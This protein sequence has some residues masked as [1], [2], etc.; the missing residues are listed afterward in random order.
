MAPHTDF[1]HITL[2]SVTGLP[3][4]RGAALALAHSLE[5]MP[6]ARAL[7]CSP[8]APHEM[9]R[10]ISHLSIAPLN[11]HEYSWFMLFALWRVVSTEFALVVQEDGWLLDTANWDDAFLDHDYVGA[12][13][14]LA[15]IE[16]NEGVTWGRRFNWTV[17]EGQTA[18]SIAPVLN[19][20]F[21]LRSQRLMRALVDRPHIRVEV[22]PPDVFA[23]SP[24]RMQWANDA[25]QED[26][27]LSAV[28]RPALEAEGIRFAP[29]ELARRFSIEHAGP[30]LHQGFDLMQLLGHH[31]RLR[32]LVNLK[33]LT[34]RSRIQYDE[35]DQVWGEREILTMFERRGYRIEFAP[36]DVR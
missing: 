34:L 15:R 9:P 32:R 5:R 26:V 28:L 25:L 27:Q 30:Q 20:G 18:R 16:T 19:G 8:Q 12:P 29:L 10:G 11:Y 35:L 2:V 6:G 4:A 36:G 22:P 31:S 23:A 21:S 7:L 14:H 33:P 3:D 17:P 1:R 13:I 24:L